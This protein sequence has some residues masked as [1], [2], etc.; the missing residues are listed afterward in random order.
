MGRGKKGR[1]N[2]SFDDDEFDDRYD[3]EYDNEYDRRH[4]RRYE[5][6]EDDY[7]ED[8]EV[9]Y[10][11]HRSRF[12]EGGC[13]SIPKLAVFFL[14]LGMTFGLVFGLV[15]LDR[16]NDLINNP[17]DP[18]QPGGGSNDDINGGGSND[19]IGGGATLEPFEFMQC[20]ETGECCNGLQSNCDLR[21]NEM[22]WAFVHNANHDDLLVANNEAP[23]EEALEAGYRGLMLDACLCVDQTGTPVL[24]F[25]HLLCGIGERDPHEVFTNINTFLTNNPTEVVFINFEIS[26]GNPTPELIWDAVRTA[27]LRQ[28]SFLYAGSFPSMRNLLE[29]GKQLILSKHGGYDCTDPSVEGC[30]NRI[31]EHF[32]QVLE[33]H[34]SFDDISAIENIAQSCPATRGFDGTKR[35][36]SINNFVTSRLGPSKSSAD[37]INQKAFIEKRITDCE[38]VTRKTTNFVNVDFWQRGDLLRVT[39]EI[40]ISRAKSSRSAMHVIGSFIGNFFQH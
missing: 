34:Y 14:F 28:K 22:M 21:P 7:Q 1:K 26:H 40:N 20:P 38:L 23:L 6:Y 39:Q 35:F 18:G 16:I 3:N 10:E 30:T 4:G 29:S 2:S 33:T 12:D 25:C 24:Q 27:G 5:D 19:D 37:V 15:D 32:T 17:E 31:F 11:E 8:Y 36:Y 9:T 13:C